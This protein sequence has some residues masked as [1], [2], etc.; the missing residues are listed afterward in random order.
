MQLGARNEAWGDAAGGDESGVD[1]VQVVKILRCQSRHRQKAVLQGDV[2]CLVFQ[3]LALYLVQGDAGPL[4]Y[5]VV[6]RQDVASSDP[7][8]AMR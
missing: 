2:P 1:A 8:C 6:E 5:E 7:A 4:G 3:G